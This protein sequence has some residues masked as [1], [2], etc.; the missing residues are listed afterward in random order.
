MRTLTA[1][2]TRDQR[3]T[4]NDQHR[5]SPIVNRQSSVERPS[6]EYQ[7]AFDLCAVEVHRIDRPVAV[8][9]SSPFYA[10]ELLKR[11]DGCEF[12]LVPTGDWSSSSASIGELLGPEVEH[13]S[14]QALESLNV[15]AKAIVWA[16]P[17]REGGEQVLKRINQMLFSGGH[18]YTIAS[19]WLARFLPEWRCN[20]DR[21]GEHPVGLWQTT[22][23]L[24]QGG[25][26]VQALYGFHGP[27]SI[28]WGYAFRLMGRL[29]LG[30]LAD[31][32]LFKMRAEYV[33]SGGQALRVPVGVAVARRK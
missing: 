16:E 13:P 10:R 7:H 19:G 17:E 2:R 30:D 1:D 25:F 24:R 29:S 11:L 27:V 31:R 3:S 12:R 18:L 9:A 21:P 23:W 15:Q 6:L 14:V 32:C 20:D 28:L 26:T 33:V 5:Q 8:F 4:V 22:K